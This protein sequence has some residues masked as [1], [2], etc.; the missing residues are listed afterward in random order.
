MTLIVAR[1]RITRVGDS[2]VLPG[3]TP[4][5]VETGWSESYGAGGNI[6]IPD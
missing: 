6:T 1:N 2:F 3:H 4:T 5:V